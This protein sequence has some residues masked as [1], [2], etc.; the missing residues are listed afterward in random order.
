MPTFFKKSDSKGFTLVEL[1]VVIAIIG[2][3]ATLLLLQ[4]GVARAKARDAK[5]V[6]DVNQLRSA[7]ELYY[8]DN[9]GHYPTA[10]TCGGTGTISKYLSTPACPL[11]PV[12]GTAYKYGYNPAANP[13]QFHLWI[14]MET[15][16][17]WKNGDADIDSS[18]W[19]A[20][21]RI[22]ASGATSEACTATYTSTA[23]DCLYDTGQ[24]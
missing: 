13:V 23:T 8:D 1:L 18:G 9:Q 24:K 15:S 14:Q 6:A 20:G 3:L 2:T 12:Q 19:A 16:G 22:N 11:D 5:R 17:N 21:D 10:L 4:L 7:A